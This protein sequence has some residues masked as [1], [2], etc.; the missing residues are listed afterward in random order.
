MCKHTVER[1]ANTKERRR[2]LFL[3]VDEIPFN[4]NEDGYSIIP[5]GD[6]T[7]L[8]PDGVHL[9]MALQPFKSRGDYGHP[10]IPSIENIKIVLPGDLLHLELR[11][12]YRTTVSLSRLFDSVA[13]SLEEPQGATAISHANVQRPSF[14]QPGHEI[15]GE[16]PKALLIPR[17]ECVMCCRN[18]LQHLFQAHRSLIIKLLKGLHSQKIQEEVTII[19]ECDNHLSECVDWLTKE[20]TQENLKRINVKTV[21]QCRGVEFPVLVTI[22]TGGYYGHVFDAWT[23]VTSTLVIIHMDTVGNSFY[24]SALKKALEDKVLESAEEQ[25]EVISEETFEETSEVI[26]E[27]TSANV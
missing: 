23:R 3:L 22:T 14:F 18:P 2:D 13:K 8:K 12:V 11:R 21:D 17:C 9:M 20:V 15:L 19:V 4:S 5:S 1:Q 7:G 10:S 16:V 6:W 24:T 26:S 27:E 25:Q